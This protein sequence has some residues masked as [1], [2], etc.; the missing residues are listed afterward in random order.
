[1]ASFKKMRLI[2]DILYEKMNQSSSP[3]SLDFGDETNAQ[4]LD[5]TK[6][7]SPLLRD[8]SKPIEQRIRLFYQHLLR[9]MASNASPKDKTEDK[10]EHDLELAENDRNKRWIALAVAKRNTDI[11][12][13]HSKPRKKKSEKIQP[14]TDDAPDKPQL[15]GYEPFGGL[16][17]SPKPNKLRKEKR[18]VPE[19]AT[20]EAQTGR[21]VEESKPPNTRSPSASPSDQE[22]VSPKDDEEHFSTADEG[23]EQPEV[24][25]DASTW[26]RNQKSDLEA[27]NR[28][29]AQRRLKELLAT[30]FSLD[31]KTGE[32]RYR[33]DEKPIR[34]A[35]FHKILNS[36]RHSICWKTSVLSKRIVSREI[37]WLTHPM[38]STFGCPQTV[39]EP[40]PSPRARA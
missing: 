34:G 17:A 15:I 16:F 38:I 24:T 26:R 7:I 6:D 29:A 9:K 18:V 37:K 33:D 8:N 35:D 31:N 27:G 39:Q 23:D 5:M 20:P 25:E 32:M 2:P 13:N 40:Y 28:L 22:P 21:D 4:L 30:F 11:F 1:M 10:K 3:R 36:Q 12:G 19:K 14:S